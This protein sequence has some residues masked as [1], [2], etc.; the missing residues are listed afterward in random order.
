MKKNLRFHSLALIA[1]VATGSIFLLSCEKEED[2]DKDKDKPEIEY[3]AVTDIDG[4]VYDAVTIG[5]QTWMIQDLK[6]SKYRNGD[7]IS[8]GLSDD[9]WES[10]TSGACAI[11][12]NDDANNN[13]YGKLYNWYA[14][15][16]SRHLCP[17]GWHVPADAEWT[18]LISYLGGESVAGGKLKEAG[19][20]HWNNPNS[21]TNES[22]FAALPAGQR[23]WYGPYHDL[24]TYGYWWSTSEGFA[25][26]S[27]GRSM[28]NSE[29]KVVRYNYTKLVGFSVRCVKD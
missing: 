29:N 9:D 17:D 6:T 21:A 16:D 7:S 28:V 2:K 26:G 5:T 10:A 18:T 12:N 8:A 11:Y 19:T 1:I 22:G 3:G 13:T 15:T 4:N 27:W 20:T 25:D 23:S 24:G 14:V